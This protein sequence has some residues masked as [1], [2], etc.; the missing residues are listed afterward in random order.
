MTR[1]K[2][3]PLRFSAGKKNAV[4]AQFGALCYRI[5]EN[6][7]QVLIVTSRRT[8]RWIVPKGWPIDGA[9]PE[10]AALQEAW[11]EA[12]VKGRVKGGSL[13]FFSYQK[14]MSGKRLACVVAVFPVKVKAIKSNYPEAKE[15]KRRWVSRS[16]AAKLLDD[17]ALAKIVKNFDPR[18]DWAKNTA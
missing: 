9:T 15:R 1:Q 18:E 16:K 6:K 11:E 14:D 5:R 4:R 10:E 17:K 8:R 12:G 2:T 7:V 3:K 13:G